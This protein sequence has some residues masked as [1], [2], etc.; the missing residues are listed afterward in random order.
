MNDLQP[1]NEKTT[2]KENSASALDLRNGSGLALIFV[3][4]G[5]LYP[6]LTEPLLQ[7]QVV[8]KLPLIGDLELYNE[9]QSIVES[10]RALW[11]SNN[12]LV[13]LLILIFSIVVPLTK[14]A[15][16]Y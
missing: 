7:I 10:I 14:A 1:P 15:L 8:A 12:T 3:S 4:L 6:G 2:E 5:C 13:A 16:Q 9:T 11:S